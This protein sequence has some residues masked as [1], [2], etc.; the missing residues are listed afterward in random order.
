MTIYV[1]LKTIPRDGDRDH[2]IVQT[3]Y[4]AIEIEVIYKEEKSERNISKI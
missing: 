2:L 4:Q 3:V 1:D